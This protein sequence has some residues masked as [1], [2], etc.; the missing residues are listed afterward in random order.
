MAFVKRTA[1]KALLTVILFGAIEQDCSLLVLDNSFK[2]AIFKDVP[3]PV[4]FTSPTIS[5]EL[6]KLKVS[7]PQYAGIG[8]DR[9][10]ENHPPGLVQ[11][12][13]RG[14]GPSVQAEGR[15]GPCLRYF[16]CPLVHRQRPVVENPDPSSV[17]RW[18]SMISAK[19]NQLTMAPFSLEKNLPDIFADDSEECLRWD[20]VEWRR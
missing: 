17:T 20:I 4:A 18:S 5:S 13:F 10:S 14:W 19:Y 9:H 3:V 6:H 11:F 2:N 15:P 7:V 8:G 1:L 16:R 12:R